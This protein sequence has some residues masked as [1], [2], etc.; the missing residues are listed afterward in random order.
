[1]MMQDI[2]LIH[3]DCLE[4]M[5]DIPEKSINMILTDLPYG[6]TARNKWDS[7]IPFPGLWAQYDRIIKD[8]GAIVLFGSG[9]F[10][11]DLMESNKK[12][13]RYNLRRKTHRLACGMKAD[14]S[15]TNI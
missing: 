1:M 3:G 10:T 15:L 12:E 11:A 14:F 9:M 13:W 6:I 8:N 7:V 5:Q 4:K 2:T